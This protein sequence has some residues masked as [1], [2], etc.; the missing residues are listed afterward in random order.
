MYRVVIVEDERTTRAVLEEFI[1]HE[2]DGFTVAASF[3]SG[4]DALDYLLVHGVDLI[5]SDICMS[6]L[7]GLDLVTELREK[8]FTTPFIIVTGYP[9]FDYAQQAIRYGVMDYMVKPIDFD[10]LRKNL[11]KL[12]QK[13]DQQQLS[14]RQNDELLALFLT[15][16]ISGMIPSSMEMHHLARIARF[17]YSTET[18]C[19]QAVAI[20]PADSLSDE[21][22]DVM[23]RKLNF[24]LQEVLPGAHAYPLHESGT[25]CYYMI[26]S[27]Q[28]TT[29]DFLNDLRATLADHLDADF[30]LTSLSQTA[31]LADMVTALAEQP[32]ISAIKATI[33]TAEKK[34]G[35]ALFEDEENATQAVQESLYARALAYIEAHMAEDI[36]REDVANAI[37][38]SQSYLSHLFRAIGGTS[39]IS[40][41]TS[42]RMQKAIDLLGQNMRISDIVSM[43]GYHSKQS[44]LNN[45]R[46][47]TG[48][49]PSEYRLQLLK[50]EGTDH[51]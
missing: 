51:A 33:S 37:Y 44:F 16:A 36:T 8:G 18:D 5:I 39:F 9:A 32:F 22:R 15:Y 14:I 29:P 46:A 43:I 13:M 35:A 12:R 21:V 45:F 17:P 1:R 38:I 20:T 7:S 4:Q 23:F 2:A 11:Q 6:Q 34:D 24:I 49:T 40:Y 25:T 42:L 48:M 28:Q 41:L 30:L 50:S 3:S 27:P 10:A 31:G 19:F 47:Y 26:A